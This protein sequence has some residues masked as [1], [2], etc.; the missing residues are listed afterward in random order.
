MEDDDR[1]HETTSDEINRDKFLLDKYES[2][3]SDDRDHSL[4]DLISRLIATQQ[5]SHQ[6][7]SKSHSSKRH[8]KRQRR[9]HSVPHQTIVALAVL[10]LSLARVS[11]NL[12]LIPI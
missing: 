3:S 5:Q 7:Q 9:I 2:H 4:E 10:L 8:E 1:S 6:D 12:S 11:T